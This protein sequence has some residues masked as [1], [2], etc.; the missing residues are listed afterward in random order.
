MRTGLKETRNGEKGRK[1]IVCNGISEKFEIWFLY[2]LLACERNNHF[3][4][5]FLEHINIW[6][7]CRHQVLIPWNVFFFIKKTSCLPYRTILSFLREHFYSSLQAE[8]FCSL[9]QDTTALSYRTLLHFLVEYLYSYNTSVLLIEHFLAWNHV[10]D[11]F[12][13]SLSNFWLKRYIADSQ[14]SSSG[15][16]RSYWVH[17]AHVFLRR[18]IKNITSYW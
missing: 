9:R 10:E 7:R 18:M 1:F 11:I 2:S 3:S 8:Q 12:T 16:A 14:R 17:L 5:L 4:G 13:L 6:C 15:P